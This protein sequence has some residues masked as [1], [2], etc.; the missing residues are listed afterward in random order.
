MLFDIRESRE[1]RSSDELRDIARFLAG[2]GAEISRHCA[3]VAGDAFHFGLGR[4]FSAYSEPEGLE[5][6]VFRDV[7]AAKR[8]LFER[9]GEAA[10]G[11]ESD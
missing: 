4:M 10:P 2:Q 9:R 7:E 8:W 6:R 3:I 11:P 5:V 1:Q